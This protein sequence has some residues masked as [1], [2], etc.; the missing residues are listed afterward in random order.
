MAH[1]PMQAREEPRNRTALALR[2]HTARVQQSCG[3]QPAWAGWH[4]AVQQPGQTALSV[5]KTVQAVKDIARGHFEG[6]AWKAG[7]AQRTY[8]LGVSIGVELCPPIG[9]QN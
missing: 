9:V 5:E 7:M 8:H 6:S 2:R 1:R 4:R 3:A